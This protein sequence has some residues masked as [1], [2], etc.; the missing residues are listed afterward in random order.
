MAGVKELTGSIKTNTNGLIET[1][2]AAAMKIL[3]EQILSNYVGDANLKSGLVKIGL[4]VAG[5]YVLPSGAFKRMFT[6]AEIIDGV[7]DLVYASGLLGFIG[8]IGGGA[9]STNTYGTVI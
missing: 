1:G 9:A 8:G 5:N 4:G 2:G 3:S 7:E 6:T